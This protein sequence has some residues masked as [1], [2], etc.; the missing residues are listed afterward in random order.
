MKEIS[1]PKQ[2]EM[3]SGYHRCTSNLYPRIDYL[4]YNA[5]ALRLY[6]NLPGIR[7][8][9]PVFKYP[10]DY[11]RDDLDGKSL[12]YFAMGSYRDLLFDA[13]VINSL[14]DHFPASKIDVVT[15]MDVFMLFRQYGFDGEWQRYPVPLDYAE[16]YDFI[17]SNE[18]IHYNPVIPGKKLL[19][20]YKFLLPA[21]LQFKTGELSLNPAIEKV[22]GGRNGAG[23][24]VA[25]H[26]SSENRISNYPVNGYKKL[27]RMLS[28]RG[29]RVNLTGFS[30]DM[31]DFYPVSGENYIGRHALI[32]E[33]LAVLSHADIIISAD[34]FAAKAGGLLNKPVIV[35]LGNNDPDAYSSLPSVRT[36][37][38]EECCVPCYRSDKCSLGY[39]DCNAFNHDSI[40]PEKIFERVVSL[41]DEA[42]A[43]SKLPGKL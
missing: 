17:F 10:R 38:S 36:I 39:K 15:N 41:L 28:N 3:Q 13:Q 4:V 6:K 7:V 25:I 19:N 22:V 27:I 40:S 23:P 34:S 30:I 42:L 18:F 43:S 20:T 26:V 32:L 11:K 2:F 29:I 21:N 8:Q 1:V 33:T 16:K 14:R 35:L 12:L 9:N 31:E 5:D 37:S 24:S